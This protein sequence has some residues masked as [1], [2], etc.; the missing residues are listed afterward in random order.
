MTT[1][2]QC[3]FR[4][5]RSHV[6]C[7]CSV[8]SK[9]HI[10]EIQRKMVLTWRIPSVVMLI[11]WWRNVQTT[12]SYA[13]AYT[14]GSRKIHFGVKSWH[15]GAC[16][17]ENMH[18]VLACGKHVLGWVVVLWW[19][20]HWWCVITE[21]VS[22]QLT[23]SRDPKHCIAHH[24]QLMTPAQPPHNTCNHHWPGHCIRCHLHCIAVS[25][26]LTAPWS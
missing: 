12:S 24:P 9:I 15:F 20:V 25:Q 21:W 11:R 18:T 2:Y 3:Q 1:Y 16:C 19:A 6:L 8:E 7:E 13:Y 5:G 4:D 10:T 17:D 22:P 23:R 14:P 26:C